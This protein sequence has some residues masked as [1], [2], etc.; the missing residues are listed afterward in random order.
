MTKATA[1]VLA[2]FAALVTAGC[3]GVAA[4]VFVLE[5]TGPGPSG[6]VSLRLTEDGRLSCNGGP[7]IDFPTA[8]LVDARELLRDLQGKVR[9]RDEAG[10]ADLGVRLAPA[11]E[12]TFAYE[13]RTVSGT[14][15][16]G[17]TS[18]GRPESFDQLAALARRL[19]KGPCGLP[20]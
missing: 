18:V 16:W 8:D 7:L 3:G 13:V 2:G 9:N 10:P 5:R 20:R 1:Y 12:Q 4:D 17:D 11:P 14:V 15:A 6:N 19:S